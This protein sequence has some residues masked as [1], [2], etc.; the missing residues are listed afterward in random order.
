MTQENVT[1]F[2]GLLSAEDHD[3]GF[4]TVN[5]F[6]RSGG[7]IDVRL[8]APANRDLIGLRDEWIKRGDPELFARACLG[9]QSSILDKVDLDSYALLIA[10]ALALSMGARFEQKMMDFAERRSAVRNAPKQN[11]SEGSALGV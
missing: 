9:E 6:L 5:V 4:T 1:N 11:S 2:G 8:T 3:A 10:I 7:S